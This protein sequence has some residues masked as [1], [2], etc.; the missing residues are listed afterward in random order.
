M[1][2]KM[3]SLQIPLRPIGKVQPLTEQKE[4]SGILVAGEEEYGEERR[5]T[6]L[7]SRGRF[8]KLLCATSFVATEAL[9]SLNTTKLSD[10]L[11]NCRHEK[12]FHTLRFYTFKK[13]SF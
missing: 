5:E 4:L 9:R 3:S 2:D 10:N 13:F 8:M 12:N 11:K 6:E 1:F 7:E